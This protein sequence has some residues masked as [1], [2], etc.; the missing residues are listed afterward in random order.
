M[1]LFLI[2]RDKKIEKFKIF[3]S[4]FYI[5]KVIK[6]FDNIKVYTVN[7]HLK[8]KDNEYIEKLLKNIQ[9]N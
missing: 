2:K 9:N 8:N 6:I 1:S 3:N 7:Q 5:S 4:N